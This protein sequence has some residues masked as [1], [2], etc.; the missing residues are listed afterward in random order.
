MNINRRGEEKGGLRPV[1][2]QRALRRLHRPGAL[3]HPLALGEFGSHGDQEVQ[4]TEEGGCQSSGGGR[5]RKLRK[6]GRKVTTAL[7][8]EKARGKRRK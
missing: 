3:S 1:P 6:E 5:Q 7:R 8:L 4:S 2:R